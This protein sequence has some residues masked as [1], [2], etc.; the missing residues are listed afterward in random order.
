MRATSLVVWLLLGCMST[1]PGISPATG[2][3]PPLALKDPAGRV[4]SVPSDPA[5]PTVVVFY[6]GFW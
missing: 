1:V 6:R 4:T 2:R 3:P 5:G